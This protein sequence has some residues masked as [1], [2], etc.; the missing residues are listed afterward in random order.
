MPYPNS[1]LGDFEAGVGN[2]GVQHIVVAVNAAMAIHRAMLPHYDAGDFTA[3]RAVGTT[4]G[5]SSAVPGAAAEAEV[6]AKATAGPTVLVAQLRDGN[7]HRVANNRVVERLEAIGAP[8]IGPSPQV[9]CSAPGARWDA[10][11][12]QATIHRASMGHLRPPLP[13]SR[14]RQGVVGAPLAKSMSFGSTI[15]T[16]PPAMAGES[17]VLSQT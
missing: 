7:E 12:E 4:A 8:A 16:I 17:A 3:K 11:G 6:P 9:T 14:A 2:I 5:E 13:G 15:E 10:G 1:E